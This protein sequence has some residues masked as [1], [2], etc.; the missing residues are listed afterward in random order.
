MKPKNKS[1]LQLLLVLCITALLV[2]LI[3]AGLGVIIKSERLQP[4]LRLFEYALLALLFVLLV[5]GICYKRFFTSDSLRSATRK[6]AFAVVLFLLFALSFKSLSLCHEISTLYEYVKKPARGMEGKFFMADNWLGHRVIPNQHG[7]HTF[8]INETAH[9]KVPIYTNNS[10]CRAPQNQEQFMQSD[11][12]HL[13]LG[14]SFTWGD[15]NI[16]EETYPYMVSK[17]LGNNYLNA[18]VSAY[19]LAQMQ[20]KCNELMKTHHFKYVFVQYSPWLIDRA[21][22]KYGPTFFGYRPYPYVAKN[23][24]GCYLHAPFFNSSMYDVPIDYFKTSPFGFADKLKFIYQVGIPVLVKDYLKK[25]FYD[26]CVRLRLL[27]NADYKREE[28]VNYT[29]SQIYNACKANGAQMVIVKFLAEDTLLNHFKY[30]HQVTVV[31]A[32]SVLNAAIPA[33]DFY[34]HYKK[35]YCHTVWDGK[36]TVVYDEHFNYH[37]HQLITRSILSALSK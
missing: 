32:D 35:T 6:A 7:F 14:C 20:L 5:T 12:I 24:T 10:G 19:G 23:D 22:D 33:T 26:N 37:A 31:N 2:H 21:V 3:F 34:T 9:G 4:V 8:Y 27:P 28:V 16:A 17:Q 29:Y 1:D 15:Y 30:L 25:I 36:D 18:G 13:F 11:T